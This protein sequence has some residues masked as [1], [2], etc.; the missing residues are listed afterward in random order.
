MGLFGTALARVLAPHCGRVTTSMPWQSGFP[1]S[2]DVE[3]GEGFTEFDRV[4]GIDEVKDE[5]D[6]FIFPD[7]YYSKE[8]LALV[9]EGKRVWGSRNADE[10]EI[11]RSDAK[12]YFDTLGIPQGPYEIITGGDDLKKY[13]KAQGDEKLWVKIDR[14]RGD[15]ETFPVKGFDIYEN[16]IDE[17]L[18]RLGPKAKMMIFTVERHLKDTLD[19]AIDTHCVDDQFPSVALLGTEKKGELYACVRKPWKQMPPGLVA[20]YDALRETLKQYEY[21]NFLSLE[22]RVL[23][24]K[25]FLGDPCCRN[26]SPPAELQ[27]DMIENLLDMMWF[28]AEGKMIDPVIPSEHGIMLIIHSPWAE[29]H[30][31]RIDFPEKHRD[32]IKFRYDSVFDGKTWIM[33]QDAG[34]R[35]AA[36][37]CH[38][39]KSIEDLFDE[40][41]EIARELNGVGIEDFSDSVPALMKQIKQFEEWGIKF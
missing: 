5:T 2:K 20:I 22:S 28:G 33:P 16:K 34:P 19:L 23:K 26:G 9:E 24:D 7:I 1:M 35:V 15:M 6:L 21:R 37:C 18:A 38:G 29:K 11:Y 10:L 25:F 30:P 39:N 27:F 3:V 17:V 40:A 13:I 32:K 41:K 4:D 36:V 14:T 8:Q 31:L 12:P